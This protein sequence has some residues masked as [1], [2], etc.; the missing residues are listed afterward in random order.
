[1]TARY[2]LRK[3]NDE[4]YFCKKAI[5]RTPR[6]FAEGKA[7]KACVSHPDFMQF[8]WM[9]AEENGAE[10]KEL[11]PSSVSLYGNFDILE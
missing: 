9:Y 2:S 4:V 11:F 10:S 1:M 7:S 5:T 6:N 3:G 8:L